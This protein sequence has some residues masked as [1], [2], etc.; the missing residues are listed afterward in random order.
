MQEL[1][2]Q[3]LKGMGVHTVAS[4]Y[5]IVPSY[6]REPLTGYLT[7]RRSSKPEQGGDWL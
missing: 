7:R 4:I 2:A 1:H 6:H 5:L 3:H